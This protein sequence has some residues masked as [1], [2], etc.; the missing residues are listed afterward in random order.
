MNLVIIF[1]TKGMRC[2]TRKLPWRKGAIHSW[3]D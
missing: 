2:E 3:S 1:L